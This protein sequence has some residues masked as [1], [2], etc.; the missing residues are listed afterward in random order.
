VALA[1]RYFAELWKLDPVRA[2]RTGVHDY[3][4]KLDDYSESGFLERIALAR[5][6]RAELQS[7]DPGSFGAEGSYDAQILAA[8]V[9]DSLVKLQ[10]RETWRH[11]PSLYTTL[12][13]NGIYSLLARDYAPLPQRLRSAIARERAIPAM[14]A[15]GKANVTTV[16]AVTAEV[17][18]DEIAGTI[19]FFTTALPA[20]VA[21]SRDAGLVTQFKSAN[22]AAVA[23][24]QDYAQAMNAGPFAHP[25]GTFAV[26]PDVFERMLALQELAPLPLAAY[27]RI[28]E[29]ALAATRADFVATAK[30][31][32][33]AKPPEAVAA[34]LGA[35]HPAS[36]A[37]IRTA[38][39]D[40]V[41]LR[42]FVVAH[43]FV[44]L[45]A[46][47]DV[48]VVATPPF[49]R[50]TTFA[51]LNAPGPLE[52]TPGEAF[53][54]VTPV[55]P[56]WSAERK[57]QHLAYFNEYAF[58]LITAHEVT[59]GHYL[60]YALD[61]SEKL[62]QI[63]RLLPS[64]SFS[65]GWAHYVEQALVD[66]GWGNG[67]PHVRLAELQLA[68]QR[69]CRFLVGLREHT[70]GMSVEAATRFFEENA[71]L[72][73]EPAHREALRGT[74]DPLYGCY[75]L[76]KLEILKLRADYRKKYGSHYSLE[77]FHDDLL[78]HGDPPIA[79]AR[80]ILL[81]ADDDGRLL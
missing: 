18:R 76:G 29:A 1:D 17:A 53:Y 55:E 44:T 7:I 4:D 48:K 41:A 33:P 63:R 11:D 2:T 38:E 8:R 36:D 68:L 50:Q 51:S 20:A 57:E 42:A 12:A 3:D 56:G 75:T 60:N 19:G 5:R 16:D 14:L 81:G 32:D 72:A 21:A 6:T 39:G 9:D 66:E 61:R 49:A 52:K 23:A 28:G 64:A 71:Y 22:Q 13:A 10:T 62:S 35:N 45:P 69:E 47:D 31:I 40:I 43:R 26:G 67:D 15:A 80:K 34:E 59:P 73:E 54:N 30:T 46:G 79:I 27:E 37:L 58:P 78:A 65:E 77:S 74:Q 24:L 70:Q 25:S